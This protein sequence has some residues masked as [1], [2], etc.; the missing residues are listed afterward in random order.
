MVTTKDSPFTKNE[1][2]NLKEQFDV[3]IKTVI[4]I[5]KE[6]CSAGCDLHSDSEQILLGK[7]SKQSNVWGS[8]VDLETKD[9]DFSSFL[10]ILGTKT[11]TLVTRLKMLK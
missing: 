5:E 3:Y 4:D 6:I 10:S 8:G 11:K 1:L 2:E 7:G 9:I